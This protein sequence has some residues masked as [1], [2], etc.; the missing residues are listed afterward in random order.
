MY[1][2]PHHKENDPDVVR[3]FIG[4]YPLATLIGCDAEQHPVATQIPV[5]VEAVDGREVLRGH[6]MRKTDH[7]RAFEQN[8]NALVLF[9][10]PN[11]YV[12][13]TWYSNPQTASTWNYMT[14]QVRGVLRFLD[15]AGLVDIL[16]KTTLH[17][18]DGNTDSETIFDNLPPDYTNKLLPAIVA[19]EIEIETLDTVFKLSQDRDHESYKNIIRELRQQGGDAEVIAEE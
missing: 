2:L 19:F 5:F 6:F 9:T 10:G 12:S 1:D 7:H 4:R 16:R 15:E 13:G 11:C 18:E 8:K 3:E 14:G 17:F